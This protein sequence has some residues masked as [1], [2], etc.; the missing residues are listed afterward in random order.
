MS[1][2]PPEIEQAARLAATRVKD[3]IVTM[4]MAD[5]VG[6]VAV[7]VSVGQ[8]EPQKRVTTRARAVKIGRGRLVNVTKVE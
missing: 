8:L 5:E 4:L 3:M 7:V 6:E 2:T 1:Q